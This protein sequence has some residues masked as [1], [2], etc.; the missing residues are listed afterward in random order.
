MRYDH[1]ATE[2]QERQRKRDSELGIELIQFRLPKEVKEILRR[3]AREKKMSLGAYCRAQLESIASKLMRQ[4]NLPATKK[5][6]LEN[7]KSDAQIPTNP[8]LKKQKILAIMKALKI[9][10]E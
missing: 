2:R 4:E 1:T 9:K 8:T 7:S 3:R 6:E 10:S 5:I